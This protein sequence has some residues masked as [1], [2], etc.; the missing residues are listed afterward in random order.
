MDKQEGLGGDA[1]LVLN[2]F[3]WAYTQMTRGYRVTRRA[4]KTKRAW[5]ELRRNTTVGSDL[6]L[7]FRFHSDDGEEA[8]L[9]EA[10]NATDWCLYDDLFD[11]VTGAPREGVAE[12][13]R[14]SQEPMLQ[15]FAYAH[16][17]PSLQLVSRFFCD[18]ATRLVAVVEPGPE[19]TQALRKLL[20]AKDAGVRAYVSP[21][22]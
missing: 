6:D 8:N 9:I 13:E 18:L 7:A 3:A 14:A 15:W 1:E 19:R 16:L 12:G 22:S 21:G 5:L 10:V 4:W 17:P 20:E 2:G 11:V